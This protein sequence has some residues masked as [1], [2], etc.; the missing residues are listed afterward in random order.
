M[1]HLRSLVIVFVAGCATHHG[2][3]SPDAS[4]VSCGIGSSTFPTFDATCNTVSDCAIAVH[5][6]NCCGSKEALGIATSAVAAFNAAE[7]TCESEYPACGCA[8]APEVA[9]DGRD[10]S[11]GTITVE[12]SAHTC[13]TFVQ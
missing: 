4:A 2:D 9:Q 10:A 5:Q 13:M 11:Q 7:H 3:G 1:S 12:C 6:I 8:E